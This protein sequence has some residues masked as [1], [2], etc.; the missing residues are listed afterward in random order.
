MATEDVV[1]YGIP[2]LF[3][4]AL[5]LIDDDL[6]VLYVLAPIAPHR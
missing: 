2:R 1:P 4:C 3:N 5:D 6:S